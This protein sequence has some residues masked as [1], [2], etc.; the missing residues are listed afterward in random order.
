M[1]TGMGT[2]GPTGDTTGSPTTTGTP[3][4]ASATV[5]VHIYRAFSEPIGG[6]LSCEEV[7]DRGRLRAEP[8]VEYECRGKF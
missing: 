2:T 7:A 4:G 5:I 1:T 6:H 8:G 3:E